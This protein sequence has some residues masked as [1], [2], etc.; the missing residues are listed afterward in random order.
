M[1][2][3]RGIIKTKSEREREARE[4]AK[5]K[6]FNV[7]SKQE[8][9]EK[10]RSQ[11]S[12]EKMAFPAPKLPLPGHAERFYFL[13][14]YFLSHFPVTDQRPNLSSMKVNIWPGRLKTQKTGNNLGRLNTSP[15]F[16][17]CRLTRISTKV[18][19]SVRVRENFYF[20]QNVSSDA[21]ICIL[22]RDRER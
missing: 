3:R 9:L 5:P 8:E 10:S 16:E 17:R 1:L 7:W 11:I 6:Y 19:M 18:S 15:T 14:N 12:R 2:I 21:W 22:L 4:K 13:T 20:S